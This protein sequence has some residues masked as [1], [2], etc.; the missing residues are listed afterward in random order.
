MRILAALVVALSACASDVEVVQPLSGCAYR[1][2]TTWCEPVGAA[3]DAS[4]SLFC[5]GGT[6]WCDEGTCQDFCEV[7][8]WPRCAE[9]LTEHHAT[10]E[11]ADLCTCRL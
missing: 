3:C 7:T 10:F 2:N 6:A 5:A 8:T 9:G 1:P 11:G 4:T